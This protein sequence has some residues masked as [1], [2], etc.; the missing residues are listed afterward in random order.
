MLQPVREYARLRLI[1]RG[2][3]EEVSSGFC[4]QLVDFVE[5][6]V[7]KLRGPDE[8]RWATRID[9]E[10]DNVRSALTWCVGAARADLALRLVTPLVDHTLARGRFEVAEWAVAAAAIPG[11]S[12]HHLLPCAL[13]IVAH[14]EMEGSRFAESARFTDAAVAAADRIGVETPWNVCAVR[15]MLAAAGQLGTELKTEMRTLRETAEAS[16]DLMGRAVTLFQRATII[17]FGPHPEMALDTAQRL[18]ALGRDNECATVTAMGLLCVGWS[19]AKERP[20]EALAAWRD[21]DRLATSVGS[22]TVAAQASRSLVELERGD[23]NSV[24]VLT[25]LVPVLQRFRHDNDLAQ[26]TVTVLAMLPSFV[27]L[28]EVEIAA[29]LCA[30]LRKTPWSSSTP[31]RAAEDLVASRVDAKA[32]A[33]AFRAGS[34]MSTAEMVRLALSTANRVCESL[35]N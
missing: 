35:L 15:V 21:A 2:V 24:S 25:R 31:L 8:A 34:M 6:A 7:P 18:V 23:E 3:L 14:A 32:L 26:Q 22:R 4:E 13:G 19:I 27:E 28:G 33:L 1:E 12:D 29:K 16:G 10:F 9:A 20:D 17:S 11:A 30:A 5:G